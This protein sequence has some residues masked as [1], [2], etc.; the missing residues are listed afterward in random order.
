MTQELSLPAEIIYFQGHPNILATHRNTI[1]VT[2]VAEISKRA[3]CIVGVNATKACLDLS[4]ALKKYVQDS[5]NLEF[6]ILVNNSTFKFSGRGRRELDLSDPR[7]LVLRR[8]DF[9]SPRTAAISCGAAAI[10]LP[11]EMVRLL[12]EPKTVGS[13][14]I[15]A[16]QAIRREVP[17]LPFI[18]S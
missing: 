7:E 5:G 15:R 9:I 11:R 8:S 16:S 13:L 4:P 12:Q 6:E 18:E 14:S 3:D 10:D 17:I 2:K 1:E